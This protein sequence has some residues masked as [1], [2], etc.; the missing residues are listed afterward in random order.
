[1]PAIDPLI[2]GNPYL[3]LISL[4]AI[5]AVSSDEEVPDGPFALVDPSPTPE[6]A[7]LASDVVPACEKFLSSLSDRQRE[8]VQLIYWDGM[9]QAECARHLGISRVAVYQR[10]SKALELGREHLARYRDCCTLH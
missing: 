1:M 6:E 10:L 7:A 3:N 8:V 4:D 9:S 2:Y 5:M